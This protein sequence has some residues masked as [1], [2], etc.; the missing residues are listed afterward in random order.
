MVNNNCVECVLEEQKMVDYWEKGNVSTVAKKQQVALTYMH[1]TAPQA[2]LDSHADTCCFR[3][4]DSL[5]L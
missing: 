3:T 4:T 2:E 1:S 5:L